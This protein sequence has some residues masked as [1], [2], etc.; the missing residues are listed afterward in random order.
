[1]VASVPNPHA[2]EQKLEA[3]ERAR[4][5]SPRVVS[6]LE[7]LL[8][9][10]EEA[11]LFRVSPLLFANERNVSEQ[12]AI[13]LLLHASKLGLF[14][15]EWQLVCP[16]CTDIIDSQHALSAIAQT[17]RC[18]LCHEQLEVSLDDFIFV[19]FT[20]SP[21]V[22]RIA[23]HDPETLPT[24]DYFFKQ[25]FTYTRGPGGQPYR[26]LI[27][28]FL[29]IHGF[30]EA[31]ATMRFD[32]D[33]HP[34]VL[35]GAERV[36]RAEFKFDVRGERA[37]PSAPFELRLA[38]GKIEPNAGPL[39]PGPMAIVVRNETSKRAAYT[40]VNVGPGHMPDKRVLVPALTG[41]RLF[42]TQTFADLFPSETIGGRAGLAL[43]DLTILFTDLK[44]STELYDRIGD[45]AAFHLVQQ[46][47]D[48]IGA[49]VRRHR[50]TIVKTIGDAVMATF[51]APIDAVAAALE[52][53]SAIA[54]FNGERGARDIVLKIGVHR[55]ASIAVTLNER[56][57]YFG[58]TVN[59]AAR[60]QT[61]ADAD[62]IR[63]TEA[64][65]ESAGVGDLVAGRIVA[66]EETQL[67]GIRRALKIC[68]IT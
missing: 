20:V 18:D 1:M 19:S 24:D 64:V 37:S 68:T 55:G 25:H 21:A 13:D 65:Y 16:Q 53:H 66:F 34:G 7:S 52:M 44:G 38:P 30:I 46:H 4:S 59:I 26:Q 32:L 54:A 5:W 3:L 10:P 8:R 42:V 57:D 28:P 58:Q 9:A 47:F 41:K 63:V 12:E 14:T 31:G 35:M 45:L 33:L 36:N 49:A 6:K 23:F 2:L 43:K 61:L 22:R 11:Q 17:F 15:M 60:V 51:A 39:S 29:A 50:G 48:R 40:S 56:L 62:E 27:E 67:K